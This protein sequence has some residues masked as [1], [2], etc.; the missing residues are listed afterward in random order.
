MLLRCCRMQ[1]GD[2]RECVEDSRVSKAER[3]VAYFIHRRQGGSIVIPHWAFYGLLFLAGITGGGGDISLAKWAKEDRPIWLVM[4]LV[5]WLSCLILFA[6][7]IRHSGRS[8]AVT[9]TLSAV[10]HIV[11]VLGW[12]LAQGETQTSKIEWAG[13]AL[14]IVGVVLIEWGQSGD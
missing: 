10:V 13:I 5:S 2:R 12:D 9:F 4:G 7:L 8:L 11:M 6:M 3:R 1:T 14:A